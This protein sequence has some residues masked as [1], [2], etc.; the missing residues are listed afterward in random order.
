MSNLVSA[1]IALLL[2][3]ASPIFAKELPESHTFFP[4]SAEIRASFVKLK[5]LIE[6]LGEK[7]E[8]T[9][10]RGV[11][12]AN[13]ERPHDADRLRPQVC[14]WSFHEGKNRQYDPYSLMR[15]LLDL[16]FVAKSVI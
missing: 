3:L 15:N 4:E 5:P 6:S 14:R 13:L 8:L 9:V 1:C 2:G 16:N 7:S 12:R 10:Y 11:A